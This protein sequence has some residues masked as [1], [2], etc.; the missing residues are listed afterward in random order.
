MDNFKFSSIVAMTALAG[1]TIFSPI[2]AMD[3]LPIAS[4]NMSNNYSIQ[5]YSSPVIFHR[6]DEKLKQILSLS[7]NWGG[8]G[9]ASID[10][11]VFCNAKDFLSKLDNSI[12]DY[13]ND[14]NILPTPYGT[15]TIDF[16]KDGELVSVEIGE[17]KIGFFTDFSGFV[18]SKS[19]GIEFLNKEIPFDLKKSLIYLCS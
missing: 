13:L 12:L 10:Y 1:G 17:N 5:S 7:D 11:S 19:D 15:I 16:D 9:F 14:E 4:P 6:F 2:T 8:D 18:N 3:N